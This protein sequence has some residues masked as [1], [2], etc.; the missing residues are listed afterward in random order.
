MDQLYKKKLKC[1]RHMG[2]S[3]GDDMAIL[4]SDFNIIIW[5]FGP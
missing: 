1:H 5:N 4:L 3:L 2:K